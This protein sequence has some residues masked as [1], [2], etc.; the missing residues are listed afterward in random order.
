LVSAQR[1]VYTG[2]A[3][4]RDLARDQ[5]NLLALN[6]QEL[7][8]QQRALS[9]QIELTKALGGGYQ[10]VGVSASAKNKTTQM[11]DTELLHE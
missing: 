3:D 1:R 7:A 5:L 4:G 11:T 10:D 2:L 8:R 9:A 6:D